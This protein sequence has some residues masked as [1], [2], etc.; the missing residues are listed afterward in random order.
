MLYTNTLIHWSVSSSYLPTYIT[1]PEAQPVLHWSNSFKCVMSEVG[2]YI[3]SE[4]HISN[5][6]EFHDFILLKIV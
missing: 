2:G 3:W 1:P 6:D 5:F 4:K